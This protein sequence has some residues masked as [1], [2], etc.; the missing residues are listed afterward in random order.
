MSL[1]NHASRRMPC[2]PPR[3]TA[4]PPSSSAGSQSRPLSLAHGRNERH[5]RVC[6]GKVRCYTT[7]VVLCVLFSTAVVLPPAALA[8]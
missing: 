4:T 1:A 8:S 3:A 6:K 5:Q 7:V 2:S